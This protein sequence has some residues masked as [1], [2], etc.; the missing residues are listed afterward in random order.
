MNAA[1]GEH[2]HEEPRGT[3]GADTISRRG[4]LN[5]GAVLGVGGVTVG[6]PGAGT[7]LRPATAPLSGGGHATSTPTALA[8][9]ADA[10]WLEELAELAAAVGAGEPV[11]FID[12]DR[13]DANLAVLQDAASDNGWWV[14]P[15]LKSLQSP[16]SI[17]YV[18]D[19]LPEPRGMV[20]HL[21]HVHPIL[22][23]APE[24]TDLLTGYVP[25]IGEL[26][27][28]LAAPPQ[29]VQHRVRITVDSI[30]LLDETIAAVRDSPRSEPLELCLELDAGS[31]RGG[32]TDVD[33]VVVAGR[34]IVEARDAVELTALLCY[35]GHATLSPAT[36]LRRTIA[37]DARRRL[38]RLHDALVDTAGAAL[39]RLEVNGPGSSNY[40]QWSSDEHL[41]EI[42]PGSALLYAGYL[43][44]GF[45]DAALQLAC[46]LSA[47][48]LRVVG[49][50][51]RVPLTALELPGANR[52]QLMLKGGGWP[53]GGGRQPDLLWPP[54]LED[55]ELYGGRGNNTGTITAP[56]GALDLGDHILLWPHQ[57]GDAIDYFGAVTAVR[58]GQVIERW[59]TFPRWG[60]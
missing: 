56:A 12:L 3:K 26:A 18:L 45:D 40:L 39:E 16:G 53:A 24:G 21:R 8:R 57:V 51:P 35:D 38:A 54:G 48:V 47:P 2:G 41:T 13:L 43:R 22:E 30:P 33:E 25:T 17:A 14:R 44:A 58:G 42:S 34:R 55:N 59:S 19:A 6:L 46:V 5:A 32:F 36:A 4:F 52:Q 29:S 23:L 60:S 10:A 50:H 7:G 49:P 15:S 28:Y 1:Q 31:G 20:F 9:A 37:A 11:C 27:A